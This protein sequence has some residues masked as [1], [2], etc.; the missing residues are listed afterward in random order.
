MQMSH[1][2]EILIKLSLKYIP[3]SLKRYLYLEPLQS[4]AS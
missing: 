2:Y 4:Y 3:C 1:L